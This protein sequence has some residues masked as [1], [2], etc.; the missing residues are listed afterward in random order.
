[1]KNIIKINNINKKVL[2]LDEINNVNDYLKHVDLLVN[3]SSS[4]EGFPNILGEA[5]MNNCI[6]L[7]SNI[8]DNIKILKNNNLIIYK[9]TSQEIGNKIEEIYNIDE[10]EKIKIKKNLK[11]NFIKNYSIKNISKMYNNI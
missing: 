1:M 4:S 9:L 11:N 6:C 3:C 7:A 10:M 5:I 2:L 8:S